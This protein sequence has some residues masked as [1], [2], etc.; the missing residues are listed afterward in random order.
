MP[1]KEFQDLVVTWPDDEGAISLNIIEE[2]DEPPVEL[3]EQAIQLASFYWGKK[4]EPGEE[5][6]SEFAE[7]IYPDKMRIYYKKKRVS[8]N[9]FHSSLEVGIHEGLILA[10]ER[11]QEEIARAEEATP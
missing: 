4:Y 6:T 3:T 11:V 8:L 10:L 2:E 7:V 5:T 9:E 1:R